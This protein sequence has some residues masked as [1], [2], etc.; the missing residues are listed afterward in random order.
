VGQLGQQAIWASRPDGQKGAFG[1]LNKI[2]ISNPNIT[3]FLE[4]KLNS[5]IQITLI[6]HFPI[7]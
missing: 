5:K 3:S 4:F 1:K 7:L 2:K 6:K